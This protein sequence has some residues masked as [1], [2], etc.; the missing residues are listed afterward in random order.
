MAGGGT[1]PAIGWV[2]GVAGAGDM[3][4]GALDGRGWVSDLDT[5]PLIGIAR[6]GEWDPPTDTAMHIPIAMC[7]VSLI[8]STTLPMTL[9][10]RLRKETIRIIKTTKAI[11][12]VTGSLQTA[13]ARLPHLIQGS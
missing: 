1:I 7:T 8:P 2:G 13:P 4:A 9:Q 3:E 6:G 11:R 10:I 12:T 5:A